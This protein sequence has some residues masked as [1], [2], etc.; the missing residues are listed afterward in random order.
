MLESVVFRVE[1]AVD[2]VLV[3]EGAPLP[4][5]LLVVVEE[6]RVDLVEEPLLLGDGL[7]DGH[8]RGTGDPVDEGAG[9]PLVR[10]GQVEELEDLEEASEA[11]HVPV[12]VFFCDS[13]LKLTI[14]AKSEHM[15]E[16]KSLL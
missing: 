10:E 15:N 14:I 11:V 13:T 2:I 1:Q 6:V 4:V 8:K 16:L 9:W 12:L 5:H 3:L 7:L